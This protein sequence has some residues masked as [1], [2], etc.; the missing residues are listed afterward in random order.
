MTPEVATLYSVTL[1]KVLHGG[2]QGEADTHRW[3]CRN[4]RLTVPPSPGSHIVWDVDVPDREFNHATIAEVEVNADTGILTAY[5]PPDD[6]AAQLRITEPVLKRDAE[7]ARAEQ[8]DDLL[9]QYERDG[10]DRMDA[11]T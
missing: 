6:S 10:W 7:E 4:V 8:M 5:C 1:V 2:D 11:L 3:V 9:A